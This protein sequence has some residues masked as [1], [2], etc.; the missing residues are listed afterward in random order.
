MLQM[1]YFP[2]NIG[3]TFECYFIS[4]NYTMFAEMIYKI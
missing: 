4:Q 2:L 3:N 1:I